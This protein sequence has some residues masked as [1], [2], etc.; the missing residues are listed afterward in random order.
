[1]FD[2]GESELLQHSPDFNVF[3][4]TRGTCKNTNYDSAGLGPVTPH[5]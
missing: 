2:K 4:I 3:R 5:L 1:M